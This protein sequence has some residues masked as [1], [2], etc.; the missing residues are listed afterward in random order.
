MIHQLEHK[1]VCRDYRSV[2]KYLLNYQQ[3]EGK[4]V[5]EK[6][7]LNFI[8]M[9]SLLSVLSLGSSSLS[10]SLISVQQS[11]IISSHGEPNR[12]FSVE[13]ELVVEPITKP[14]LQASQQS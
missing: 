12:E 3:K 8:K 6:K 14:I 10:A 13:H 1:Y 9:M 4:K 5:I 11:S 7:Y 2:G